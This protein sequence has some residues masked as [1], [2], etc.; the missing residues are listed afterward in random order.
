VL[1]HQENRGLRAGCALNL[2]HSAWKPRRHWGDS[3]ENRDFAK[4]AFD[5]TGFFIAQIVI[6]VSN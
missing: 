6:D 1:G 5:F 3:P 2:V 4:Q